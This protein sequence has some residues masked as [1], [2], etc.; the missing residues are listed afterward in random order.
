[1]RHHIVLGE[2]L[3]FAAVS[4]W[5]AKAGA[6]MLGPVNLSPYVDFN[7]VYEDNIFVQNDNTVSDYYFIVSPG[8]LVQRIAGENQYE[9]E[10]RADVFRYVDTGPE[11]DVENHNLRLGLAIDSP[12]RLSLSLSDLGK[13]GHEPRS[14]Q[15]FGVVRI[16]QINEYWSNDAEL[17]LTYA[18]SERFSLGLGYRNYYIDY[19]LAAQAFRDR[20]DN[21][22]SLTL[23]YKFMPKTSVLVEGIYKNVDH[24]RSGLAAARMLDSNEYWAMAGLTWEV[25]AK[26]TGTVKAGYEWKIFKDPGSKDFK[27]PI[28]IVS[29]QHDFSPKTS[30]TLSGRRQAIETDDP[31]VA[32]YTTVQADLGLAYRPT[33][34]IT[35]AATGSWAR[36]SYADETTVAGDNGRRVDRAWS[37]GVD[38]SYRM[39]KWLAFSAGYRH[40]KRSSTLPIYDYTDNVATVGVKISL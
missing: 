12:S 28:F 10:Y 3:L 21:G 17:G 25:T 29:V 26:S 14:E 30:V 35:A 19:D 22:A 24:L 6:V 32:Y 23:Y 34:K 39:N 8:M 2:I 33:G 5:A 37:A 4:L 38:I 7:A 16:T 9:L 36:D 1:M 18:V 13:R 15:N 40:T 31:L 20:M 11:N 27:S